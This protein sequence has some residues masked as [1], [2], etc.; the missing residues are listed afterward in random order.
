MMDR[1]SVLN[2]PQ[3]KFRIAVHVGLS[4]FEDESFSKTGAQ[5]GL[6]PSMPPYTLGL[7]LGLPSPEVHRRVQ[8][9]PAQVLSRE[10]VVEV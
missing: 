2:P 1:F 3:E 5:M 6:C 10:A 8:E 7:L 4:R 9:H